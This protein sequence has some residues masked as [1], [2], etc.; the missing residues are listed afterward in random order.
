MAMAMRGREPMPTPARCAGGLAKYALPMPVKRAWGMVGRGTLAGGQR[1]SIPMDV[2][3]PDRDTA[4]RLF[5]WWMGA[6][7][8]AD[9]IVIEQM[10]TSGS[11]PLA[12]LLYYDP[13][14]DY[15]ES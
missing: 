1:V 2:E 12:R 13:V 5:V 14:N 4:A 7:L 10:D 3:A 15:L 6:H 11:R 8:K 9:D